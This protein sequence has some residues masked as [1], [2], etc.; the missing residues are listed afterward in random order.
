MS[1][2]RYKVLVHNFRYEYRVVAYKCLGA[3]LGRFRAYSLTGIQMSTTES[4]QT[5]LKLGIILS[6]VCA[7]KYKESLCPLSRYKI[8]ATAMLKEE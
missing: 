2:T 6:K 3:I 7:E 5:R 8:K 4:T 1:R